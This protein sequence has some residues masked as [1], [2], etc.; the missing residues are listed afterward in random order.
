MNNGNGGNGGFG[1]GGGGSRLGTV[2]GNGGY[3]G[4]GGASYPQWNTATTSRGGTFGGSGANHSVSGGGGGAGLGGAIFIRL[5]SLSLCSSVLISNSAFHGLG[6]AGDFRHGGVAGTNGMGKGGAVT[7]SANG[8]EV[9]EGR[10]EKTIP[11][12]MSIC[13]GLDIGMDVGSPVDFTYKPPFT[14]T[15]KIEKVTIELNPQRQTN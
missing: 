15:G 1:G 6:G 7:L 5:G 14:F 2:G 11:N 3:G 8:K 10:I 13:E 12:K 4:G 9:A